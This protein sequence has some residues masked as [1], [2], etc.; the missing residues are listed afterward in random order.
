MRTNRRRSR[1]LKAWPPNLRCSSPAQTGRR[2]PGVARSTTATRWKSLLVSCTIFRFKVLLTL[3][4]PHRWLVGSKWP[5]F[6]PGHKTEHFRTKRAG[7]SKLEPW[8]STTCRIHFRTVVRFW[9]IAAHPERSG[10][11]PLFENPALWQQ[12]ARAYQVRS[13]TVRYGQVRT[14]SFFPNAPSH[15]SKPSYGHLWTPLFSSEQ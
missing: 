5:V 14:P 4:A 10:A 13:S 1:N 6:R 11:L 7:G 2:F 9:S 8:L 15:P 12:R 3:T